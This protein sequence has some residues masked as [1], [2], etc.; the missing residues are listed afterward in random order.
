MHGQQNDKYT[1]MHGQ[2]N[3]KYTE[4][5]GQQNDKYTEMHGQQNVKMRR[6][7][8]LQNLNVFWLRGSIFRSQ[9]MQ[10][11]LKMY[12]RQKY[13]RLRHLWLEQS[14]VVVGVVIEKLKRQKSPSMDQIPAKVIEARRRQFALRSMNY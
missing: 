11:G 14:D 2:Q 4:M 7:V 10:S 5:H 9:W 8:F 3:D 13:I 1:E 6:V 12:N